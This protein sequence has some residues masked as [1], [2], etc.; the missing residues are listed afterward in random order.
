MDVFCGETADS[1]RHTASMDSDDSVTHGRRGNEAYDDGRFVDACE[2]YG[3]AL[4]ASA[5][6]EGGGGTTTETCVTRVNRAMAFVKRGMFEEAIEDC[7]YVL[8]KPVQAGPKA[9]CKA[10]VRRAW[11]LE[12]IGDAEGA[13]ASLN[14]AK[15]IEPN[16][17][18]I[19]AALRNYTS[20]FH[21]ACVLNKA[22]PEVLARQPKFKSF[23]PETRV[24]P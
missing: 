9:V 17:A 24:G 5:R 7:E 12:G 6:G 2:A 10:L 15:K 1:G 14:A 3:R 18:V 8:R 20:V 22:S 11:A 19:L 21:L 4:E 23:R 13:M 16:N